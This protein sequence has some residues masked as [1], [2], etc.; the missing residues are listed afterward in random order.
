[1]LIGRDAERRMIEG[2]VAGARNGQ[3]GVLVITGEPGIGKTTLLDHAAACAAGMRVLRAAGSEPEREIPFGAL[4]QVLRPTLD[5]IDEIPAPQA[6]ALSAALALRPG[7]TGDRFAVGAATLSLLCRFAEDQPLAILLDD[8]PLFDRPSAAALTFTARRLVADPIV[9]LATS[10]TSDAPDVRDQLPQ[11]PLAGIDLTA[12]GELVS[13]H[14]AVPVSPERVARLHRATAGNPLALVELAGAAP[15]ASPAAPLPVPAALADAFAARARSLGRHGRAALTVAAV[16]GTDLRVISRACQLLDVGVEALGEAEDAGLIRIGDGRVEFRHPLVRAA[17]YGDAA[18]EHRR[19]VHRAVADALGPQEPDRHAWHL[20][21]AAIGPDHRVAELLSRAAAR[22]HARSAHDIAAAAFERAARLCPDTEGHARFCV[23]AAESAW[24]AGTASRATG[25][26]DEAGELTVPEVRLLALEL[27]GAIATRTGSLTASRDTLRTAAAET[28]DADDRVVLLADAIS[29]CFYLCDTATAVGI[30]GEIEDLLARVTTPKARGLGQI[31]AG[32]AL[33]MANR[34]GADQLRAAVESLTASGGLRDDQRRRFWLMTGPLYLRDSTTGAELRRIVHESRADTA[35]GS[36]PSLLF[37]VA[38]DEA[39][40]NQWVRAAA[41]YDEA[42]RLAR[43]TGQNTELAMSLAGLAW[44]RARLGHEP[45]CR[46]LV[47][48]ALPICRAREIHIGRI[49]SLFALGELELGLGDPRKALTHLD[50]LDALL[51]TLGVT[52]PDLSPA[53]ERADALLRLGMRA[54]AE[55]IAHHYRAAAATKDQPWALA[56]AE[57]TLGMLGAEADLDTHF[58]RALEFHA[59]TLDDFE[60]A[61]TRLAYGTRLRR[62]RRRI[63][64]R[65]Q[66]RVALAT[67][68]ELGATPWADRAA[69]ELAATGETVR[70]RAPSGAQTLTPQ[71]LQVALLLSE[72]R[73]TREVAAALFLSPKTVEYH[74]RKVY[75]KLG[76]RSRA[77]LATHLPE[78]G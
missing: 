18:P 9:L 68:E 67:F 10:R 78:Q 28:P 56:R 21:E 15:D 38:R 2:L 59:R 22:A 1:M 72:G 19:T 7:T 44:L 17:V 55:P 62:A 20:A 63:A 8:L 27:R 34:G 64:A 75:A 46:T 3:G 71:E 4:H 30:A 25:L 39:T 16:V 37:H 58:T 12:A 33:V 32:A 35:V 60:T 57:R 31:A 11:L 6:Q 53:P 14:S 26:L 13:S 50:E 42:I 41:T 45:Q 36:L 43:E 23:A 69:T 70:R 65:P 29:A 52:D 66:L 73:T 47:A 5:R 61:R 54:K 74:L 77:E 40:T 24:L 76:V 48:E 49:W 51:G